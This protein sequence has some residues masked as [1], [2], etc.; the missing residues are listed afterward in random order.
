M[1]WEQRGNEKAGSGRAEVA[2]CGDGVPMAAR[3]VV[4]LSQL[5]E[6]RSFLSLP[7]WLQWKVSC[8]CNHCLIGDHSFLQLQAGWSVPWLHFL[9]RAFLSFWDPSFLS[10]IKLESSVCGLFTSHLSAF[11]SVGSWSCTSAHPLPRSHLHAS[12]PAVSW[13]CHLLILSSELFFM[14]TH[15]LFR[16]YILRIFKWQAMLYFVS[17]LKDSFFYFN[18]VCAHV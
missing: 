7:L 17:P 4:R 14:F 10:L 6:D 16:Y 13:P 18:F 15:S 5:F 1:G 11:C 8:Y 2:S 12:A 9:C 3:L